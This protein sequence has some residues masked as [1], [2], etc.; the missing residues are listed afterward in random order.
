M[1]DQDQQ[2][3]S[4]PLNPTVFLHPAHKT[5]SA[6]QQL[7]PHVGAVYAGLDYLSVPDAHDGDGDGDGDGRHL[8]HVNDHNDMIREFQERRQCS[9][10]EHARRNMILEDSEGDD[11]YMEVP[12]DDDDF[13]ESTSNT[14]SMQG[15]AFNAY[16]TA[17]ISQGIG[18]L[19]VDPI[20]GPV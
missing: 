19:L 4:F 14:K 2:L 11:L 20:E 18:T 1:D 3:P 9:R 8:Q 15:G 5:R 12:Y 17:P 10:F 6:P 13:F 7:H 16:Q